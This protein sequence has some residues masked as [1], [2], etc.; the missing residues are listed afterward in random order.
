[1]AQA[2]EALGQ[3]RWQDAQQAYREIKSRAP[4]TPDIDALIAQADRQRVQAELQQ[5]ATRQLAAAEQAVTREQWDEAQRLVSEVRQRA[6]GTPG[7]DGAQ[8]RIERARAA[9]A[10][11]AASATRPEPPAP[12]PETAAPREEVPPAR[13][14][15]S[16]PKPAEVPARQDDTPAV[17][18]VLRAFGQG[19]SQQ[20]LD[21]M[22]RV[23]PS[24]SASAA[25]AYQRSFRSHSA[26]QWQY[27]RI[28]IAIDGAT[29]VATCDVRVSQQG[30]RDRQMQTEARRYRITLRRAGSGWEIV[31]LQFEGGR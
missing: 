5:W 8:T 23:W 31:G 17:E 9:S 21:A 14:E 15:T 10:Q 20:S 30:I 2:R 3:Q 12:R 6:P 27:D 16:P 18:A 19:Y 22:K 7:L 1:M 25:D 4:Q 11:R 28:S 26:Q 13:P 24:M 29:A